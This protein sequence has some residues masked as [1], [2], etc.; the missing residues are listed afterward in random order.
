M[1]RHRTH[2]PIASTHKNVQ[3]AAAQRGAPRAQAAHVTND[4][5]VFGSQNMN[6]LL[7]FKWK[8]YAAGNI[9]RMTLGGFLQSLVFTVL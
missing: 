2:R 9:L 7:E 5:S 1:P 6:I 4:F 3:D 8:T